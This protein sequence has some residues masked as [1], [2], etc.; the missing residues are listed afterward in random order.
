MI[1]PEKL[2]QQEEED[3]TLKK[4]Q[5]EEDAIKSGI[6]ADAAA[7]GWRPTK[8][9]AFDNYKNYF[10]SKNLKLVDINGV[11][12]LIDSN[13][14]LVNPTFISDNPLSNLYG[15]GFE[16]T[17]SGLKVYDNKPNQPYSEEAKKI[18]EQ[19]KSED[20]KPEIYDENQQIGLGTGIN[21]KLYYLPISN[22]FQNPGKHNV[23]SQRNGL[24]IFGRQNFF[25]NNA[26]GVQNSNGTVN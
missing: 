8:N 2:K 19:I 25:K 7:S 15:Y 13:N 4:Q 9:N 14:Q 12:K 10:A 16:N 23:I 21:R 6:P 26:V 3:S 5:E 24:D 20:F 11:T 1:S 18:L 22:I 17:E